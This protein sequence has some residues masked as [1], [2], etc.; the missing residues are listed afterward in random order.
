MIE[1]SD[2]VRV[3]SMKEEITARWNGMDYKFIPGQPLDLP[4][5][6]A[7]HIFGFGAE[8][9]SAALARLGWAQSSDQFPAAMQRLKN[10]TF[11]NSPA[12]VEAPMPE[13][14]GAAAGERMPN[15]TPSGAPIAGGG[16]AGAVPHPA[17]PAD[18]RLG[19]KSHAR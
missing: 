13:P 15:R 7:A 5:V 17:A 14:I 10:I 2:H 12:L 9:K 11:T 1:R 16:E 8:D 4:R 19:G 6:V 3:T 18:S